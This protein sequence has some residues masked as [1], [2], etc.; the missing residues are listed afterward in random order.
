MKRNTKTTGM[1]GVGGLLAAFG[2]FASGCAFVG[3]A[4][5]TPPEQART[6]DSETDATLVDDSDRPGARQSWSQLTKEGREHLLLGHSSMAEQSLLDA[7]AISKTFRQSD[8]RRRASFGN[9]ERLA[10]NYRAG[11]D[12]S[13][14]RRVLSIIAI[15][16]EGQS[17]L[18]YPKLS[19]LLLELG[20][21]EEANGDL[22]RAARAYRRALDLRTEK[23]GAN[24][25]TLIELHQKLSAVEIHRDRADRAVVHA[26]HALE[27]AETHTGRNSAEMIAALL[28]SA[29]AHQVAGEYAT[30]EDLYRRA[31][32]T[33]R[34]IETSS[35]TEAI[36]LNGLADLEL[37]MSR[38]EQALDH[39]DDALAILDLLKLEGIERAMTLDTK[40][41]I[42]AADGKNESAQQL[43]DEVM[44]HAEA[45]SPADQRRL[46]ESYESFLL[47]QK[48]TGEAQR[49]R[50]QIKQLGGAPSGADTREDASRSSAPP[51]A[52]ESGPVADAAS[53][54]PA[55][56]WDE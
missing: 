37:R 42:L 31:L 16:T 29:N 55:A 20:S 30:S 9:L 13:S 39:V 19:S 40:A 8:V 27:L 45:A 35:F 24:S 25:P 12:D 48:R 22:E 17:E 23:S 36:A 4:V 54:E 6:L 18:R 43:F 56:S 50:K 10:K 14:A 46:Y 38:L 3:P 52:P 2:L 41:Q 51:P 44:L 34:E 21:L 15:E 33:Q 32:D 5:P 28:Q 11:D 53:P 47:D 26:R 49:I 7:F 1:T